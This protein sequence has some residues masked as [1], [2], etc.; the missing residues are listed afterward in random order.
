MSIGNKKYF[1]LKEVKFKKYREIA[2]I[3]SRQLHQP[4]GASSVPSRCLDLFPGATQPPSR[5]GLSSSRLC[6]PDLQTSLSAWSQLRSWRILSFIVEPWFTRR[7]R[8]ISWSHPHPGQIT[9]A[10]R[11]WFLRRCSAGGV[12][13]CVTVLCSTCTGCWASFSSWP[14]SPQKRQLMVLADTAWSDCEKR[15]FLG[16]F[17]RLAVLDSCFV[18][19]ICFF[20]SNQFKNF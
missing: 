2:E 19:M 6:G 5:W 15:C 14:S 16:V 8:R 11:A 17:L 7:R 10:A 4:S 3:L 13:V 1:L 9:R 20:F 18:V 12:A